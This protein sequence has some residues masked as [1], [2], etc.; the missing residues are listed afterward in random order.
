M[1]NIFMSIYSCFDLHR[2]ENQHRR[3][4][5]YSLSALLLSCLA[6][7]LAACDSG[8]SSHRQTLQTDSGSAI[9]YSTQTQ[10][11]LAR[12]FYGGGKVGQLEFTP[13][14]SLY[15]DG[16]FITGSDLQPHQGKLTDNAL[17][18]LLHTITSTDNLLQ[19]HQQVFDDIPE[20]NVTLLQ[21]TL[22]GKNYQFTYGPF[23]HL[24]Q[25][26][27]MMREYGQL[28]NAISVIR[29]ALTG[30]VR[31]YTSQS[32]TLLVY[33][34]FRND[35]TYMQNLA[36]PRWPVRDF[37]LADAA[38]YECGIIKPDHTGPNADNGCLVYTVPHIAYLLNGQDQQLIEQA[39]NGKTQAMFYEDGSD[40]VVM[41][42]PLLPDEIVQ[43]QLA[44][45]G[46]AI[47]DYAPIPLKGGVVPVPTVTPSA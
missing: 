13:E 28:G 22:N 45:Y 32:M 7:L 47:Q 5:S 19:L 37:T 6:L 14:I 23:G 41:L 8:Q 24:Q 39:L 36:L 10:D 21:L 43:Q 33:Q 4:R 40:Y 26:A 17:Q 35:F 15:G 1:Q 38:I 16:T 29:D 34:T 3:A 20:Q 31:A 2:R 27:Q 25:S 30:P 18:T 42:R 12:I 9:S 46:S 44:M 11:V